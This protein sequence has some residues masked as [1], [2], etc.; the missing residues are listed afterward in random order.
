LLCRPAIFLNNSDQ[1]TGLVKFKT[2]DLRNSKDEVRRVKEMNAKRSRKFHWIPIVIATCL[3]WNAYLVYSARQTL[4]EGNIDF[5]SFYTAAQI[6]AQGQGAKL[7]D[8]ETQK[9]FQAKVLQ[10]IGSPIRFSGGVL[11]YSHLPPGALACRLVASFP[12]HQA[13]LLWALLSIV[14]FGGPL[15]WLARSGHIKGSWLIA[16][17][18]LAFLPFVS[19][20]VQGQDS[21]MAWLGLLLFYKE[22]KNRHDFRAGCWISLLLIKLL[23]LP[24]FLAVLVFKRRWRALGGFLA[25]AA[26]L[27]LLSCIE[28]G[29]SWISSFIHL[30]LE[31][32]MMVNLYGV[33]PQRGECIRGQFLA[34]FGESH[35]GLANAISIAVCLGL[36]GLLAYGWK[37]KW[38]VEKPV[39]DFQFSML[40]LTSLLVASHLNFHDL[41]MFGLPCCLMLCGSGKAPRAAVDGQPLKSAFI[42]AS[43]PLFSLGLLVST[44]SRLH[45]AVWG[46]AGLVWML[47]KEIQKQRLGEG[48]EAGR[49]ESTG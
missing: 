48:I 32:P 44:G 16:L 35:Q 14:L 31:I 6:I 25:G 37:G 30:A 43:F 39:F 19:V 3:L 8:L 34:L 17:A 28:L 5:T 49:K 15:W 38:E 33:N 4:R 46:L 21:M 24:V 9:E 10:Q 18:S 11:L 42:L 45:L 22:L 2:A 20:L 7:Y 27:M 1:T 29:T 12:Y 41:V 40:V 23:I 26:S 13:H 47:F 36:L